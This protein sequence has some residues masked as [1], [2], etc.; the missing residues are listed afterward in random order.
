MVFGEGQSGIALGDGIERTT[1]DVNLPQGSLA[2]DV[3]IEPTEIPLPAGENA[4]FGDDAVMGA[5]EVPTATRRG[6]DEYVSAYML[7]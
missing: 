1:K 5:E 7:R 6:A 2:G 4:G 3:R